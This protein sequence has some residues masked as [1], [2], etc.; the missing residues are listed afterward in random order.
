MCGQIGVT[1][2]RRAA[3]DVG[4]KR[5][6]RAR[7]DEQRRQAAQVGV[8]RRDARVG[9]VDGGAETGVGELAQT[10]IVDDRVGRILDGEG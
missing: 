2:P 10:G 1:R 3:G 9:T 4:R 5:L 7:L 8:E 6:G